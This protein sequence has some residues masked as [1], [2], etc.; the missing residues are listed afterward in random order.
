MKLF[1]SHTHTNLEPLIS[2][3][4]NVKKELNLKQIGMNIVGVDIESSMIAINQ[5]KQSENFVC[6]IGIHPCNI[7]SKLELNKQIEMLEQM[8]LDNKEKI[9]CIG[10]CGLDFYHN[11]ESWEEQLIWFEKQIELAIKYKLILMIHVREA[12]Y[13]LLRTL[14]K[15]LPFPIPVI[16]HCFN[17]NLEIAKKYQEMGCYLSIPGI[18]TYKNAK[19]LQNAIKEINIDLMITETDAPYLSPV[20]KRGKINTPLNLIYTNEFIASLLNMGVDDFNKKVI[21]NVNKL[22]FNQR[23]N[24]K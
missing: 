6:S 18:V 8:Y 10:E 7:G 21:D 4:E 11:P 5:S 12:N 13:L 17:G 3:F 20:P 9:V 15:Y 1:D 24:S 16:I 19:E 2:D 14:K 22:F 23:L